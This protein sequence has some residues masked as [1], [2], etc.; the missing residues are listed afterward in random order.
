MGW[1]RQ[2][3]RQQCDSRSPNP[4]C[5]KYGEVYLT[6]GHSRCGFC[7]TTFKSYAGRTQHI[8]Q[9][10]Q[11]GRI[12]ALWKGSWGLMSSAVEFLHRT[13]TKPEQRDLKIQHPF[14]DFIRGD[15]TAEMNDI[16]LSNAPTNMEELQ[17]RWD[18]ETAHEMQ[19]YVQNRNIPQN[20][21]RINNALYVN[22]K[23]QVK[24]IADRRII[25]L[26]LFQQT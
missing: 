17:Q 10:F 25:L 19:F 8:A 2:Q 5:E 3:H 18:K 1:E 7:Q 14:A 9:H 22:F 24:K 13:T 11:H 26:Y 4:C 6:N 12:M 15:H 20:D 23:L 21:P 16:D